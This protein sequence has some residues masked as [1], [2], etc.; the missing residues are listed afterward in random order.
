MG[1]IWPKTLVELTVSLFLDWSSDD[2]TLY[3]L[4]NKEPFSSYSHQKFPLYKTKMSCIFWHKETVGS[5]CK[6]FPSSKLLIRFTKNV[7]C[8]CLW[9]LRWRVACQV[10][11]VITVICVQMNTKEKNIKIYGHPSKNGLELVCLKNMQ[12]RASSFLLSY[13]FFTVEYI[14]VKN[15]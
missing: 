1:C 13:L 2:I 8:Y 9:C 6:K 11:Y 7:L 14:L 15:T 3:N 10:S 5:I 12:S 4:T